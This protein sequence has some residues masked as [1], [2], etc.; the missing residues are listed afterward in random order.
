MDR[1]QSDTQKYFHRI[2]EEWREKA[3][4]SPHESPNV[5]VQR[6]SYVARQIQKHGGVSRFLDIGC[7][8]GE[9]VAEISTYG[10]DAEG[11]DFAESMI[12][13]AE[14]NSTQNESH[15]SFY[16]DD[17]FKHDFE[18]EGYDLISA[19]GFIEYISE[20]QLIDFLKKTYNSLKVN[21]VLILGSR[22]R[23]FN[24]FS[25]NSYTKLEIDAGATDFLLQESIA[26]NTAETPTAL[27]QMARS[28]KRPPLQTF[29]HPKTGIEVDVRYQYTPVELTGLTAQYG[30]E[31]FSIM[32][33]HYHAF[34]PKITGTFKELYCMASFEVDNAGEDNLSL[35][36]QSSSFMIGARKK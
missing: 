21:G 24:L 34:P 8:T 5:I 35:V 15:C 16:A 14:K 19:N 18:T 17:F 20:E 32:P 31:V 29:S 7:G 30:F 12:E 13:I 2:A 9:L 33:I 11:I 36:P 22:N 3:Q 26:L 4:I 10:I 27:N 6:N 1:Q 25:C 28:M 23:L